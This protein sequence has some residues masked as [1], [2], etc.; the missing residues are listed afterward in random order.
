MIISASCGQRQSN[1]TNN[2]NA[3]LKF[4]TIN[5]ENFEKHP[6]GKAA[7][8]GISYKINF[9]YPSA[10]SEQAVLQKL[11]TAF[12]HY[13]LGERFISLAPEEAMDAYVAVW[14]QAY[15]NEVEELQNANSDPNFVIGWHIECCNSILFMNDALVQLQTKDGWYPHGAHVYESSSLHL[16]NLQTGDE[17]SRDDIFKPEAVEN[18][19]KLI[20]TELL[21]YWNTE[22]LTEVGVDENKIWK[23]ETN[24]AL[25]AEGIHIAYNE[26][27]LSDEMPGSPSFTIPFEAI[28]PYLR[29]GTPVWDVASDGNTAENG[30]DK[31]ITMQEPYSGGQTMTLITSNEEVRFALSGS[32]KVSI[33]W[34]NKKET[35]E[36]AVNEFKRFAEEKGWTVNTVEPE[37]YD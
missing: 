32:G 18:I 29:E 7:T 34:G 33:L 30:T 16:F 12:I 36:L 35:E 17:Y 22:L 28:M 8:D 2:D 5:F 27:E 11:Q 24:F 9:L 4:E 19:R 3:S 31:S 6:K 23:R 15:Y 26:Y 25:T 13:T 10:Y 1:T 14:K 21:K 37:Y 20:I